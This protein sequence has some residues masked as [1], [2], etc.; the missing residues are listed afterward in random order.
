M[1]QSPEGLTRSRE[2]S[3]SS[4]VGSV[5]RGAV[6]VVSS[7]HTPSSEAQLLQ[8]LTHCVR[9]L[10]ASRWSHRRPQVCSD[11]ASI[12]LLSLASDLA[13]SRE[14]LLLTRQANL[15]GLES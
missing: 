4:L 7:L 6:A 11:A 5:Q 8:S 13:A 9:S 10:D 12:R 3:F 2:L 14:I 15:L 1:S